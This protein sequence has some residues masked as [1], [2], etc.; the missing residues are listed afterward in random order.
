ME[1]QPPG[2]PRACRR[3]LSCLFRT[4]SLFLRAIPIWDDFYHSP[5]LR[6]LMIDPPR[7]RVF[8]SVYKRFEIM[9]E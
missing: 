3:G 6:F 4:G 2:L 8:V 9:S 5:A 7:W 1:G